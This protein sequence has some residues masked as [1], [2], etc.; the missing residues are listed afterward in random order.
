[1][2]VLTLFGHLFGF[3]APAAWLAGAAVVCGGV[4]SPARG[5]AWPQRLAC[6]FGV[7]LAV[8]SAGLLLFGSDGKMATWAALVLAV[9]LSECLLRRGWLR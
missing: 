1:M 5:A 7:G 9:A 4:V 2:T 6:D 3:C 8:S